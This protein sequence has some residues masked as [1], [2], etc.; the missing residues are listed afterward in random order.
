[1][2]AARIHDYDK[3]LVIEQVDYPRLED[4]SGVI[5]KISGSGFCHSDLR[6]ISG[7][8]KLPFKLPYILG[9]EN[10]GY[11]QEL[12]EN[13][14][15]LKKGDPVLVYGGWGCRKCPVCLS[16]NEQLCDKPRWP[17]LSPEYQG[18]FAEFL[19]V[20]SYKYL[21]KVA[22]NDPANLAALTDA[23][24]TAY[25]AVRKARE[26]RPSA[27]NTVVVGVGGLGGYAVQFL[28]LLSDSTVIAVDTAD[29]K[30]ELAKELGADYARIAKPSLTEDILKLSH[31]QGVDVVLDFVGSNSTI[32][33]ALK[34]L[35]KHG[36]YIVVGLGGGNLELAATSLIRSELTFSGSRWGSYKELNEVYRFYQTNQLR[37]LSQ[38]RPLEE[39][40]QVAKEMKNA[41]ISGRVVLIP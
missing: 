39:I 17:G 30:I 4:S 32:E 9:H 31:G 35:G 25:H 33:F 1:M 27:S 40:N 26:L 10:S 13:V 12:G 11:V 14:V 15:G 16:G 22:N 38:K 28:K 3:P 41:E 29:Q 23:G 6:I 5:I 2:K 36:A 8:R 34:V 20:P 24:L 21:I 19:Y 7:E 37:I 18:G